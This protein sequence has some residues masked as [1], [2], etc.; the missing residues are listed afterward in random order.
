[1]ILG[2]SQSKGRFY[3]DRDVANLRPGVHIGP[4]AQADI[5]VVGVDRP[6][7]CRH[8]V[9]GVGGDPPGPFQLSGTEDVLAEG[10]GQLR[11]VLAVAGPQRLALFRF[12]AVLAVL[13]DCLQ[14]PIPGDRALVVGDNK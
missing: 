12:E 5:G 1:M 4:D 2:T 8:K 6:V 13:A 10:F 11:V 3:S 14:Q 9:L 7:H